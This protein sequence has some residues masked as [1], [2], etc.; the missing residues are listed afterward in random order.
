MITKNK[1][2]QDE[3]ALRIAGAPDG[4]SIVMRSH[5]WSA[6][7]DLGVNGQRIEAFMVA[8]DKAVTDQ[9]RLG[10]APV[11][12]GDAAA[13]RALHDRHPVAL[14]E[15]GDR[16]AVGFGPGERCGPGGPVGRVDDG[17]LGQGHGLGPRAATLQW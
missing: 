3:V 12:P 7:H 15:R 13:A 10:F 5:T 14:E 17:V 9:A 8:L 6:P 2:W 11:A 4:A 1:D 16:A